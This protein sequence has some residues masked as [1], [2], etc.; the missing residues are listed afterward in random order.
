MT[1]RLCPCLRHLVLHTIPVVAL[2]ALVSGCDGGDGGAGSQD[3]CNE[4]EEC[5]EGL[6]CVSGHCVLPQCTR[7]EECPWGLACV[8]FR[9]RYVEPDL[10][11]GKPDGARPPDDAG[12]DAQQDTGTR[13]DG[14]GAGEPDACARSTAA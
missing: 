12:Q 13:P 5:G 1:S 6:V 14:E 8:D 3:G 10:G 11:P 7:S 9:C 2:L 4:H